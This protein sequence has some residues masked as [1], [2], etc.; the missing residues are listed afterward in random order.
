MNFKFSNKFKQV[1]F[2][3]TFS[4]FSLNVFSQT[5]KGKVIDKSTSEPLVGA[6]VQIVGTKM[7]TLVKLDGSYVFN[8]VKP[9]DY[10]IKIVFAGYEVGKEM[11]VSVA[12]TGVKTVDFEL[13]P[14]SY[15]LSS[16][17]VNNNS[18]RDG[19]KG[20]RRIEKVADP[21]LNVLSAKTIQLLPDITVANALQRVSGVTIEKSGSGEGR[22]P[23]IRGMEKRYINTLVNGIKIPSPDNR[24]RFIPLDLFPS[25]LL[26][27]LE[28]SKSLTPSMEGDAIGGTINLV[29]KDAPSNFLFQ[30]NVSGGFNTSF[31]DQPYLKF[32]KSTMNKQSPFESNG[33]SYIA[34]PKDFS[35]AHLNYTNKGTPLNTTVGLTIGNRFGKDKK[36]GFIASGSYQ[37]I[38]RGTTSN[39]FLP[40]SQPG[41][42]NI[43]LFSDLQLR[44]YSIQSKRIGLNG[45]LDYKINKNNRI[46]L[47]TTLVR[48]DDYQ[49]RIVYDTVALNSVVDNWQRSQW[50]YQSIFNTTLQGNHQ[51]NTSARIDWSLAY[52]VAN[53]HLPDQSQFIHQYAIVATSLTA[54]K[55]QK[56]NR[57]WQ[58]NSDKDFSGYL[59]F[60]KDT[61]FLNRNLELKLGGLIRSKTRDN[62]YNSYSLDPVLGALY[63]NINSAQ[64]IFKTAA[65]GV[66]SVT[67]NNYTFKENITAGYI[68]AKWQLSEK[69]EALGGV[70]LEYTNQNYETKLG[71]DVDAKSGTI[72]YTDA[73]PS[74]QFKYAL[75]RNQNLRFAYYKAL[76]RPGFAEMIPDGPDGEFFKEVGDPKRLN[77]TIADNLDFRYE[78]YG[79][80]ADQILLGVFY[81]NIQDPIEISAVKPLNINSLYLQ[82]VNLGKATNYGFEAVVTKYFGNFGVTAN[83]TYTKS[84]IT[85]DNMI[86]TSRDAVSGSIVSKRVS[87]TRPLQGQSNH[88]G[89]LSLIYKNPKIGFDFQAAMVYTGERI[90]FVS[91]YLGLHYWQSPTTQLDISFEKRIVK[92]VTFYGKINNLT[93]TP[94]ELSLHQ[95]Y[96]DYLKASGSR[97]LALQTDPNNRIII[98]KDFY[99]TTFLF[100]VRYKF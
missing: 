24:S 9:G 1:F 8:Q 90:S 92:R 96:S 47:I 62:F 25:E 85:N 12:S 3:F 82:P 27:R 74:L 17:T 34:T 36:F 65:D 78:L 79:K 59:N 50:Q 2:F 86:Y 23:I 49:T 88:I 63:T 94:F 46:A 55:L 35:T 54:D 42:N 39:F 61:K 38:Y 57:I 52:S 16:V 29:M 84:E 76:A 15:E 5:I 37:N 44:N 97:P 69:L 95:P 26:E 18:Y 45:K 13:A 75:S 20:A 41:L 7:S 10:R 14:T 53:N 40:N 71:I 64:F 99:K 28:V 43:P 98:Q 93:N 31:A 87:E 51:L 60:T 32:D 6:S 100:G 58:H 83:Y 11:P 30:A 48:L 4:L 68:Q 19:D 66:P 21:I 80:N 67:G 72:K 70:R 91:P 77:H 22:Y 73:L 33:G 56:M 89:N 81:K